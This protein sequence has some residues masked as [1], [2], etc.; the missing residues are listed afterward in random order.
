MPGPN[1]PPVVGGFKFLS[2]RDDLLLYGKAEIGSI[3]KTKSKSSLRLI[4]KVLGAEDV[5]C[6]CFI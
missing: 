1:A 5:F 2:R 4:M 6:A 3:I